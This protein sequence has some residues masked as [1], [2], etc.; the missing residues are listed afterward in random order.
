MATKQLFTNNAKTVLAHPVGPDDTVLILL[1][2]SLFP[3]PDPALD[4][5]FLVTLFNGIRYE[6]VKVEERLGNQLINCTRGFEGTIASRY[7][8]GTIVTNEISAN[9]ANR[10]EGALSLSGAVIDDSETSDLT[11]W[12]SQK[13]S[14]EISAGGGG[15]GGGTV[16]IDIRISGGFIQFSTDGGVTWN[17]IAPVEDISGADGKSV[18]LNKSATHL[19]WRNVDDP[20]W[21]DLV[22]LV[23]LSG[24]DGREVEFNVSATH[25]QWRYSG[26]TS[27]VDLMAIA[28]LKGTDGVDGKE[29]EFNVSATHIQ[30]RYSGEVGWTDLIALDSLKGTD[31]I[32]GVDA[33]NIYL[34]KSATHIQWKLGVDGVWEDLVALADL[35]GADGAT[36][37]LANT[38]Q[39]KDANRTDLAATPA[40]VKEYMGQ[41]GIST[42]FNSTAT[43]LNN[44]VNGQFFIWNN[45][46]LN[47]PAGTYGRGIN[48]PSGS[49]YMTQVGF[50]NG[51]GKIW[52]RY[53]SNG[54]FSAWTHVNNIYNQVP[55]GGSTNQVL[56]K[57]SA[58]NGDFSWKTLFTGGYGEVVTVPA[59]SV[60]SYQVASGAVGIAAVYS[61]IVT[62]AKTAMFLFNS[63]STPTNTV[64]VAGGILAN[65]WTPNGSSGAADTLSLYASDGKVHLLNRFSSPATVQLA[66][67]VPATKLT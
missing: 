12:S 52:V 15:G 66:L 67:T 10:W 50:E 58:T 34:Q 32:D 44:V 8:T 26:E 41:Y 14:L 35:K 57:N 11:T 38:Q 24:T 63:A 46:T 5:Y 31:G 3:S 36:F 51:N 48:I 49:G 64:L 55:N 47:I 1:D 40:G 43:D 7:A 18:E 27:W 39:S 54:T 4:Q 45:A 53:Q 19:Q 30:W 23:D 29:V 22:P 59:N 25:I 62:G 6:L 17:N 21:I 2:A 60:V 56:V 42:I 65:I 20:I 9:T 16:D 61:E 13:I 28:S 37:S 33:E